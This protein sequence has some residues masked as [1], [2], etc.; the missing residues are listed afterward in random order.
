MANNRPI[1]RRPWRRNPFRKKSLRPFSW[2]DGYTT[3]AY[4]ADAGKPWAALVQP[5]AGVAQHTFRE[6]LGGSADL[7]SMD[8]DTVRVDRIVGDLQ[9]WTAGASQSWNRPPVVRIGIVVEA[10]G[11]SGTSSPDTVSLW[12]FN[13]LGQSKWQYLEELAP[14]HALTWNSASEANQY[15]W[16]YRTHLDTRVKR[17]LGKTD[18]LWL[19]MTYGNGLE[20]AA[21][22]TDNEWAGV[23]YYSMLLRA[24][25]VA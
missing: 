17:N 13:S 23:V 24:G 12:G 14:Q 3:G 6:I 19:V 15:V 18:R 10:D 2:H 4:A 9:F 8:R 5:I 1:N 7:T 20:A 16:N 25:V 22:A 11:D 21:G